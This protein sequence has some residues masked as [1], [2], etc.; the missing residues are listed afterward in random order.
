MGLGVRIETDVMICRKLN[1]D[2]MADIP[3]EADEIEELITRDVSL[4]M[5][6][7]AKNVLL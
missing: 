2:L 4:E 5:A 7:S 1:L 6:L 3:T